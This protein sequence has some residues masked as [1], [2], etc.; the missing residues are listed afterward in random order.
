[1][2][3]CLE[4]CKQWRCNLFYCP[5]NHEEGCNRGSAL[6]NFTSRDQAVMFR[7]KWG[8]VKLLDSTEP[9]SL[10]LSAVQG[11]RANINY[12]KKTEVNNSSRDCPIYRDKLG[13]LLPFSWDANTTSSISLGQPEEEPHTTTQGFISLD[14]LALLAMLGRN[15]TRKAR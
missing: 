8:T 5:W 1:L 2:L 10:R 15:E 4:P 13:C 7:R 11:F 14:E 6:I 12:Y 9:L 3:E